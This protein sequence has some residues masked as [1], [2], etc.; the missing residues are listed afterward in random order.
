MMEMA[1]SGY[2]KQTGPTYK[3]ER[4][5]NQ[6]LVRH[7]HHQPHLKS[8]GLLLL[9]IVDWVEIH[10]GQFSQLLCSHLCHGSYDDDNMD[11]DDEAMKL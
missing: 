6:I 4:D 10:Q 2:L 3:G 11:D 9:T 8:K 5:K 1:F 7:H